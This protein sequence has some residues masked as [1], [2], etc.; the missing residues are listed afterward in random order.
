M[1]LWNDFK[2]N[3]NNHAANSNGISLIFE[4]GI[5]SDLKREYILL[6]KWLRTNYI[7]P[8]HI[9]VYIL[10][11]EKVKLLSGTLAYG[12][13]RW[14]P[15]RNPIIKSEFPKALFKYF[16]NGGNQLPSGFVT[17][18][19]IKYACSEYFD[20]NKKIKMI[21]K[22]KSDLKSAASKLQKDVDE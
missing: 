2:I 18:S 15:K 19:E 12:S 10:N 8:V 14:F 20:F 17:S 11:S 22:D 1:G 9:N 6:A 16:R 13:F 5:E 7:F 21:Q 4:K 3:N